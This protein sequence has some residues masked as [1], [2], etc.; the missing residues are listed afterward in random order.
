[1]RT[2]ASPIEIIRDH[3][4]VAPISVRDIAVDF[5]I[6]LYCGRWRNGASGCIRRDPEHGGPSGFAIIANHEHGPMRR[7][8]TIAHEIAHYVLHRGKIGDGLIDDRLYR[9]RLTDSM[10]GQANDFAAFILMPWDLITREIKHGRDTVEELAEVF[11]VSKS[12]M[13]VRLGFPYETES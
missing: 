7:R 2:D 12:A 4:L 11:E 1:M 9:S 10:E 6:E 5:G 3:Q 8:F 13:A